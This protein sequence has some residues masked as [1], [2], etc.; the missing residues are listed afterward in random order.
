MVAVRDISCLIFVDSLKYKNAK[1]VPGP[2]L[3]NNTILDGLCSFF[4]ITSN[5]PWKL[6]LPT[7]ILKQGTDHGDFYDAGGN[8]GVHI[9]TWAYKIATVSEEM[10]EKCQIEQMARKGIAEFLY[11]AKN[12]ES[13][14]KLIETRCNAYEADFNKQSKK[15]TPSADRF[16]QWQNRNGD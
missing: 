11:E 8:C 12:N 15:K 7:D 10:F 3:P 16:A 2:N 14:E 9:C 6:Y 4:N 1:G 13:Y 5:K